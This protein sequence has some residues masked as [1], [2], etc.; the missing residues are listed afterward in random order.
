M[1]LAWCRTDLH[2]GI[3]R[4]QNIDGIVTDITDW[5]LDLD[6]QGKLTYLVVDV[7][8]IARHPQLKFEDVSEVVMCDRM[9]RIETYI[10]EL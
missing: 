3:S 2:G 8:G 1:Q 5:I 7:C 4:K 10:S 9:R 6:K